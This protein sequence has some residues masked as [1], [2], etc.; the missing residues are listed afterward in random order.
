MPRLESAVEGRD[1]ALHDGG[2]SR[3]RA[4]PA[5]AACADRLD[6]PCLH[7][8]G[9][10]PWIPQSNVDADI[11]PM[12]IRSKERRR[13]TGGRAL[14]RPRDERVAVERN[15]TT[16]SWKGR[17]GRRLHGGRGEAA[18][19][20]LRGRHRLFRSAQSELVAHLFGGRFL[21]EP[22]A[23]P[24]EH[25]VHDGL[26]PLRPVIAE[27][28]QRPNSV[29]RPRDE[30]PRSCSFVSH[31]PDKVAAIGDQAASRFDGDVPVFRVNREQFHR[32]AR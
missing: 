19:S 14:R 23:V 3:N 25:R 13:E 18:V 22:S 16:F 31:D 28:A 11:R 32:R 27:P 5:L 15:P 7:V 12:R 10:L 8:Q 21:G 29:D 9:H 30:A 1:E 2:R 26:E 20:D 4:E 6:G 24:V 17:H